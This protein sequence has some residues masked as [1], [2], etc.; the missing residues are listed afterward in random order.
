LR[1]A[2]VE[3]TQ[4]PSVEANRNH[5]LDDL[6]EYLSGKDFQ[7]RIGGMVEAALQMKTDLDAEKRAMERIW[8]KREKQIERVMNNGAGMYGELQGIVG[9][10]LQPVSMLEL[11]Q[12]AGDDA[13][14]VTK[15]HLDEAA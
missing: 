6:Y 14:A 12:A 8:A 11:P 7:H 2:L 5:A 13:L 15:A 10:A 4:A 1:I 9:N 3:I